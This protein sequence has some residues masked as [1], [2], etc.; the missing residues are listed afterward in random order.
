MYAVC[1][2]DL[3]EQLKCVLSPYQKGGTDVDVGQ[4]GAVSCLDLNS[5]GTRL[6]T[7]YAKGLITHWDLTTNRC[8]RFIDS[9]AHPPGFGVLSVKFTVDPTTIIFN[10]NGG[11]VFVLKFKRTLGVRTWYSECFFSGCHGE[12]LAIEPL[13][14]E[15]AEESS[16]KDHSIVALATVTKVLILSI[17]PTLEGL[18]T[19]PLKVS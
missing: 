15:N 19:L 4:Y 18:I 11:N 3:K 13:L 10:N 6:L 16:L 14:L 17:A 2:I 5:D 1:F 9:N 12:A 7:G 8:L